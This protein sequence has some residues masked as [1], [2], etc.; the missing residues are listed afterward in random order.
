MR[1]S[2]KWYRVRLSKYFIEHYE[3]YED[4]AEWFN[5]PA[6]NQWLFDI[7][8]MKIRV[9]LT[10]NKKGDASEQVYNLKGE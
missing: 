2:D 9:E 4:D 10:C 5:D 3:K 6:P 1:Y 7:P 8:H